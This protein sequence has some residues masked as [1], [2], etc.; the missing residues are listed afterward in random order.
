MSLQYETM[1]GL[2]ERDEKLDELVKVSAGHIL[3]CQ[4]IV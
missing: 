3:A 2:L 1:E 4:L